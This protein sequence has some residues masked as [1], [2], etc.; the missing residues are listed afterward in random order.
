MLVKIMSVVTGIMFMTG[1]AMFVGTL[2]AF[3]CEMITFLQM[4]LRCLGYG[5]ITATGFITRMII[6][7]EYGF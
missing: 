5:C 3:E 4:I 1:L 7:V 6:E 2:G